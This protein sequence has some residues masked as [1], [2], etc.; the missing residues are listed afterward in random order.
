MRSDI[1]N[2]VLE[3][4]TRYIHLA[5]TVFD[6]WQIYVVVGI[7][8]LITLFCVTELAKRKNVSKRAW[9]FRE[10][11]NIVI[12]VLVAC[13][14]LSGTKSM[15]SLNDKL[16][17][18]YDADIELTPVENTEEHINI[19]DNGYVND[20]PEPSVTY[21]EHTYT[22]SPESYSETLS[23]IN[24]IFNGARW[25]IFL[26]V[27]L[28]FTFSMLRTVLSS[29]PRNQGTWL[30]WGSKMLA[31]M[32]II[33]VTPNLMSS[34]TN[35]VI[36]A[37]TDG[38][39]SYSYTYELKN[40]GTETMSNIVISTED[41]KYARPLIWAYESS[42]NTKRNA[43]DPGES[44][45]ISF[46]IMA[47]DEKPEF[48]KV[49]A[50]TTAHTRTVSTLT[51]PIIADFFV[52]G[53]LSFVIFCAHLFRHRRQPM[54]TYWLVRTLIWFYLAASVRFGTRLSI[55]EMA[56]SAVIF[57]LM[58]VKTVPIHLNNPV[59][60]DALEYD[61]YARIEG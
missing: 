58:S 43:L 51:Y 26:L 21:N 19:I 7:H 29:D 24:D 48:T 50:M 13:I 28:M 33:I 32:I 14:A 25:N 55:I 3:V 53:L 49:S 4:I 61:E 30:H 11:L 23:I 38:S 1:I 40:N 39:T 16:W 15:A 6:V 60:V 45:I 47:G 9:R 5:Q 2:E 46:S 12:F 22:Y 44:V 57:A 18:V 10:V 8:I 59:P 27:S 41:D 20:E 35:T 42:P 31:L 52:M 37:G 54:W 17:R 34:L 56:V 36:P